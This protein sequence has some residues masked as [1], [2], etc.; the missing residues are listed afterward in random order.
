M[1]K[2][3]MRIVVLSS[4]LSALALAT[5][6]PARA[7]TETA[8][9]TVSSTDPYA[10]CSIPG[11][12][13]KNFPDAEVEPQVAVNPHTAG[14]IIGAWQQDRWSNGGA[15]GLVAGFSTDGGATWGET[16]LPFSGC[17]PNA[18][19]DPFTGTP[20]NRASD[21][22]VSIGPDGTAYAVSLSATN[23][24]L[25]GGGN[26]DTGVAAATS[27]TGGASWDNA[28]LIKSDQGTSPVFEA[29]HFFNDK[30]SVTADPIHAGT[31]YVAWDR[32]QAPSHSPDAA[33]RARALRGPAWFAKTTDGGKTWT[34]TRAIF[35]PGQNNRTIGNVIVVDPRT[36]VLY[37]FFEVFQTTGPPKFTPRGA[38]VGFVSSL[39]GGATWSGPTTVAT[40]Q[41]VTDTDPNTGAALRT[42]EGLPSA[43]INPSTGQLYVVWSDN[44]FTGTVN[45][46]VISTSTNGGSTWTTPAVISTVT[47]TPAFTPTVAV[48]SAG[49][50]GVTYYDLRNLPAGDTTTLPTDYWFTASSDQGKTFS[51]SLR[52]T[53]TS[54]DM[55]TAPNAGGF[56]VGDYEALGVNGTAFMPFF[57]QAEPASTTPPTDVFT[58]SITP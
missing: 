8:L 37:D 1:R 25:S 32:L 50:V 43:A 38:S 55:L 30:E 58:N 13:G 56:F 41:F 15:Q 40:Q 2:K 10:G 6:A 14:N 52:I 49:V 4:A 42:G 27:T 51:A 45:Q 16:P 33:L 29:T 7:S 46:I 17:A 54:F 47:G 21:P 5:A 26:N 12:P 23:S 28:R 35:D 18:V 31:A 20:Y 53:P 36:D 24:T 22:W 19:L 9:V 48:N 44:R 34:G 39:D 3:L 57:V 11:N